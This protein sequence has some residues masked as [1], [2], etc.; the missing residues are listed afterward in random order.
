M[1]FLASFYAFWDFILTL[2]WEYFVMLPFW[3]VVV[4][5]IAAAVERIFWPAF[6]LTEI[7]LFIV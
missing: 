1:E 2:R 3:L 7:C 5:G 6:V 4:I